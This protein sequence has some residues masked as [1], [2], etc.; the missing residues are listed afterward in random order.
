[1]PVNMLLIDSLRK[2]HRYYGPEFRVECP[3]GSGARL[4][5]DQVADELSERLARLFLL[6]GHGRRPAMAGEPR[7]D[8]ILFHEYFD[9]DTGQGLGATHQ[10]GWTALV[11]LLLAARG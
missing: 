1:M 4:D 6:D 3:V 11:V 9:G 10:T 5:L 8:A 7:D 2:F